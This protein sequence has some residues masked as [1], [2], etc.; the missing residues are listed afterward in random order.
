MENQNRKNLFE[1]ISRIIETCN[2]DFHFEAVDN[3]IELFFDR[4]KDEEK[5]TELLMLRQRKWNDIH[6]ILY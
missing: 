5:K 6:N 1:W 3:L 4:T 2:H